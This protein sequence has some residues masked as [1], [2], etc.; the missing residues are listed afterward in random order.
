MPSDQYLGGV[1][2]LRFSEA[3]VVPR[4]VGPQRGHLEGEPS[5][6]DNPYYSSA[7]SAK[8]K[9]T[10]FSI[11][12]SFLWFEEEDATLAKRTRKT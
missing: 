3:S 2:Q 6:V 8:K 4:G 10:V 1:H 9:K 7:S 12:L 11:S 5:D